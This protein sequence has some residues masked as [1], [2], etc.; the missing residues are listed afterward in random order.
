MIREDVL[1]RAAG[2]ANDALVAALEQ[3]YDPLA[4]HEFSAGFEQKMRRL[5]RCAAV[6]AFLLRAAQCAAC[7]LLALFVGGS[8][9]LSVNGEA[10]A[11]FAGWVKELRDSFFVYDY[12]GSAMPGAEP[13][14]Y[15]LGWL[16]EGYTEYSAI[17]V[18]EGSVTKIYYNSEIGSILTFKYSYNPDRINWFTETDQSIVELYIVNDSLAN[19]LLPQEKG[20]PITILWTR[21]DTNITFSISAILEEEE[22]LRLAESVYQRK[23]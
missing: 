17:T 16:P 8:V 12:E 11:A 19:I 1:Q 2:L 13:V 10:R 18:Q 14:E 15:E 5:M 4:Q 7:L 23:N 3:G 20:N 9:L 21:I 22:L 6:R